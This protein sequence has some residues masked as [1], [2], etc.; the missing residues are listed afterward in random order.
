MALVLLSVRFRDGT[1]QLVDPVIIANVFYTPSVLPSSR[2]LHATESKELRINGTG[3]IG[4]K[5]IDLYFDPPLLKD[6]A[7]EIV[8]ELPCVK[9]EMVL[10]LRHGYGWRKTAGPLFVT[11]INTGGG[12]VKVNG[13]EGV[14]V[15][16]VRGSSPDH[17][18]KVS[19]TFTEQY[20]YHDSA[21]IS[22]SGAGFIT[23]PPSSTRLKFSDGIL[24]NGVNYTI[25]DATETSLTLTLR[26]GSFWLGNVN[27]L[28]GFLTLLAVDT[29]EGFVAVGPLNSAKGRDV[30]TVFERPVVQ[31]GHTKLSKLHPHEL[32]VHGRGFLTASTPLRL[33]FNTGV[34]EGVDYSIEVKGRD[35]FMIM[36]KKGKAW[37]AKGPL[38]ITEINVF[39]EDRGEEGWLTLPNDGVHVAEIEEDDHAALERMIYTLGLLV[40]VV[41]LYLAIRYYHVEPLSFMYTPAASG[42][43]E[44]SELENVS[45]RRMEITPDAIRM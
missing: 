37:G 7:Y 20:I 39:G 25:T 11:G 32:H 18:V 6:V 38:I 29:G 31:S 1:E 10:R 35:E 14:Q 4:A 13:D 22:I 26:P 28:P 43:Q 27:Y 3:L 36:L 16:M 23:S 17:E 34:I 45:M 9:D 19:S 30:A 2:V 40:A 42:T 33:R 44:A 21:T 8:S 24:G 12:A 41:G 5:T 15:A